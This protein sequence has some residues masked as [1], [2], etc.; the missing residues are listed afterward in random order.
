MTTAWM[1]RRRYLKLMTGA[2]LGTGL[3]ARSQQQGIP[4]AGAAPGT[5]QNWTT[6]GADPYKRPDHV[7][8]PDPLDK[9]MNG[10]YADALKLRDYRPVS[11]YKVPVSNITRA[12]YPVS[13]MHNHGVRDPGQVD[14][15][16]KMMDDANIERSVIFTGGTDAKSF[17]ERKSWYAKYPNRFFFFCGLPR[18]SAGRNLSE[19]DVPTALKGLEEC[20]NEGALGVGEIGGGRIVGDAALGPIWD[21]CGKLG[22][23]VQMHTAVFPWEYMTPDN[24]N[25]GLMNGYFPGENGTLAEYEAIIQGMDRMIASHPKT[26]FLICHL[27]GLP[28]DL[29]RLGGFLDKY[30]NMFVENS[31][32]WDETCTTPRATAA[33]YKK[34]AGRVLFGTDIPYHPRM[35][36]TGFRILESEDEHFYEQD[37]FFNFNYHWPMYGLGLPDDVLKKLYH[38]NSRV[39]FDQARRFAS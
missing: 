13:D 17:N 15:W 1:N 14:S 22:L 9:D 12:K 38:D 6:P 29:T 8:I 28:T 25:D 23:V 7:K 2:A 18:P 10:V 3:A 33:F 31:A 16:V 19:A 26:T 36:A 39:L 34:Y 37:L 21:K 27:A 11:V 30:P 5:P 35:F 32:E 4:A 24:H 20:R